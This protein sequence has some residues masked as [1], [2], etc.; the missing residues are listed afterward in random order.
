VTSDGAELRAPERRQHW[1]AGAQPTNRPKIA[2]A[3]GGQSGRGIPV[4]TKNLIRAG[5]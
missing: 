2:V 3:S 4:A 5:A 1:F